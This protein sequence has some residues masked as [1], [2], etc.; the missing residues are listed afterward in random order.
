MHLTKFVFVSSCTVIVLCVHLPL[1]RAKYLFT[2]NLLTEYKKQLTVHAP[3]FVAYPRSRLS[4]HHH[5]DVSDDDDDV[6]P[7]RGQIHG[8][9]A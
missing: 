7:L 9:E 8:A 2:A 3:R 1:L 6:G 4:M 5:D